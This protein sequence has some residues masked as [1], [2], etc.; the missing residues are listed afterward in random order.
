MD[1]NVD[2]S[3][4]QKTGNSEKF[5]KAMISTGLSKT[6]TFG[7]VEQ[8]GY[9]ERWVIQGLQVDVFASD[10][11]VVGEIRESLWSNA[12]YLYACV[13]KVES[14]VWYSWWGEEVRLPY[15]LEPALISMYG[16]NYTTRQSWGY[17][18][19]FCRCDSSNLGVNTT[20]DLP[21]GC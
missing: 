3:W 11:V 2:Q 20:Q 12:G 16:P 13:L 6:S 18:Q 17:F 8:F 9:E 7:K 1:L 15:P 19:Y 14:Y 4:W 10:S 5:E 21:G